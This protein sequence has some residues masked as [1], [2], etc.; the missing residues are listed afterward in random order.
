MPGLMDK[1]LPDFIRSAAWARTRLLLLGLIT[2]AFFVTALHTP[3]EIHSDAAYDDAVYLKLAK[4]IAN[5][6]WLGNYDQLTLIKGPGYSLFLTLNAMLGLP[7][8]LSMAMLHAAAIAFFFLVFSRLLAMPNIAAIGYTVTLWAPAT[9]LFRLA[10]NGIYPAQTLLV[11]AS[12][13]L[14]LFGSAKGWRRVLLACLAGLLVAWMVITREEGIWLVPGVLLLAGYAAYLQWRG[15]TWKAGFAYPVL[16][17]LASFLF[18]QGVILHLNKTHYGRR[19]I[20]EVN[21]SPFTDALS[22]LQSVDV[23]SSIDHLPVPRAARMAIY[24]VSPSFLTLQNYFDG[25]HEPRWQQGCS[26]YPATCGDIAGGWFLWALRGAVSEQGHYQ[27]ARSAANFYRQLAAEVTGACEKG[28]L[29]CTK[30]LSSMAPHISNDEWKKLPASLWSGVRQITFVQPS[31]VMPPSSGGAPDLLAAD[32]SFLGRPIRTYSPLDRQ[33]FEIKG[34]FHSTARSWITSRLVEDGDTLSINRLDSADLV[35]AFKDSGAGR[36]RFSFL[37]AC[38]SGCELEVND[39]DGHSV[40]LNLPKMSGGHANFALGDSSLEIESVYAVPQ[41]FYTEDRY[42]S[43]ALAVRTAVA[44]GFTSV[45]PWLAIGSL[46]MFVIST[47]SVLRRRNVSLG[48]VLALAVWGLL[49]SRL[50]LLGLVDI[51]SFPGMVP[52]YLAPAYALMTVAFFLSV[53]ALVESWS[54]REKV[55]C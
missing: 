46:I 35:G 44:K 22:A 4:S 20:V 3:M 30:T 52:D 38:S 16:C 34:W 54:A 37:V 2:L 43:A 13:C 6:D 1:K 18:V 33:L 50:L 36:E 48:Y 8:N 25:P 5:G 29:R 51:S 9:F 47:A 39:E 31:F 53:A 28:Q 32:V 40:T 27:S 21:S 12:I 42:A 26:L 7:I 14:V 11:L 23:N 24:K 49:A 10:R 41:S 45:F 55:D 15:G 19:V 17:A